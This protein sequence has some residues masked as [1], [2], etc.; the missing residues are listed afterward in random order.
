M[1]AELLDLSSVVVVNNLVVVDF[2][3][4]VVAL[5]AVVAMEMVGGVSVCG[6]GGDNL[7]FV[8]R[9]YYCSVVQ[10]TSYGIL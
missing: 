4:V 9:S 2:A 3:A 1:L 6:C 7:N 5:A 10:R 8:V